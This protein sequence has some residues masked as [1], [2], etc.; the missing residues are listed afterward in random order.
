MIAMLVEVPLFVFLQWYI[1][2]Q[3]DNSKEQVINHHRAISEAE[4]KS[5]ADLQKLEGELR[6]SFTEKK[7]SMK[8]VKMIANMKI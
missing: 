2:R 3:M 1:R 6:Q 7:F 5:K 8:A 4:G